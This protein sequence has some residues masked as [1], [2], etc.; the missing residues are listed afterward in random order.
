MIIERVG[1]GDVCLIKREPIKD[2]RGFFARAFCKNE[3]EQAGLCGD[4]KQV[5]MSYNI[6]KGTL[7]GLHSQVGEDAEDKI[8]V[9]VAGE[10]FDVCVDVRTDSKTFGKW[11]GANLSAWNGHALYVPKGF[12]HGYITLTEAVSVLYFVTQFYRHGAEKG[13]RYDDPALGIKWPIAPPY[14]VSDKDR[15]WPL[16]K[17]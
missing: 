9:C 16:I 17:L 7:R 5:N 13:Y 1:P 2:E 6:E 8:V 3:L 12:A 10:I 4:I 15:A 11:Y 14:I